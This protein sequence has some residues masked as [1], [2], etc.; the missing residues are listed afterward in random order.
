MF[1][2]FLKSHFLKL[3]ILYFFLLP[4]CSLRLR[5]SALLLA[6]K[7]FKPQKCSKK[8]VRLSKT[9]KT[10]S[11]FLNQK[12]SSVF[13]IFWI[14]SFWVFKSFRFFLLEQTAWPTQ[15]DK[16]N[17]F[18]VHWILF[19]LWILERQNLASFLKSAFGIRRFHFK[20][21]IRQ[22]VN[23]NLK[24]NCFSDKNIRLEFKF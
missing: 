11:S 6:V 17:T 23:L 12:I 13:Q 3:W 4:S 9:I 14:L 1:S 22:A 18:A 7:L 16:S 10:V 2:F 21:K 8:A 19:R 24:A 5:I 15:V 20:P